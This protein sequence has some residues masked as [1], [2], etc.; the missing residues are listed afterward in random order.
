MNKKTN[1]LVGAAVLGMLNAAASIPQAAFAAD[2]APMGK[3]IGAN[4]CNG[5]GGCK[6]DANDCAGKNGCKGKGFLK[7]SEKKCEQKAKKNSNIHWEA[8]ES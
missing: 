8:N 5:K 4:A 6:S 1:L 2:K 3:C 7:M